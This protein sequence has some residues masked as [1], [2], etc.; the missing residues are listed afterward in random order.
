MNYEELIA[1]LNGATKEMVQKQLEHISYISALPGISL[2][3]IRFQAGRLRGISD[4]MEVLA[5]KLA[6]KEEEFI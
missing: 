1:F 3:E 5:F 2:D 6:K 4:Y